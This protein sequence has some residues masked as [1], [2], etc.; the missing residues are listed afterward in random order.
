MGPGFFTDCNNSMLRHW[1]ESH[2]VTEKQSHGVW[3]RSRPHDFACSI[4]SSRFATFQRIPKHI[5]LEW[6]DELLCQSA[7][8][9]RIVKVEQD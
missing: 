5:Q 8:K 6:L 4:L 2:L 9:I 7:F 1:F 3:K